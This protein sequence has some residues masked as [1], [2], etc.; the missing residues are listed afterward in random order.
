MNK[1]S[2]KHRKLAYV[3]A[4]IILLIPVIWLG[5]PSTGEEGSGGELAQLR[6]QYE[7][8]ESTL[9]DVDPSSASMNFVLLG[10]RGIATNLLWM[11][12]KD[13]Q[14]RKEWAKL[15]ST[16]DSIILLQPH[17][18]KVWDFQGW[19]LAYNVSAEWDAVED[20]Y[21]W[22]KEGIKFLNEGVARNERFPELDWKIGNLH[23]QKVGRSDEWKQFRRFYKVDPNTERYDG[24]PD[25]E[26]N[27][28][29]LDNYQVAK[30]KYLI[31]NEKE[32]KHKQHLQ[33]RM[34]FRAAPWHAQFD[35][36]NAMQR[37]GKFG[38][39]RTDAWAQGFKEWTTIFGREEFITPKGAVVLEWTD[40]DIE[41]LAKRDNVSVADKKH[42]TDRYQS[43][44]NYRFWR[45]RALSES[46][47]QTIDAHKAIYDGEVSFTEG[48]FDKA[49]AELEKGMSLY[50]SVLNKYPSLMAEDLAIEEGLKAVLLWRDIHDLKGIP[51]PESF[52]LKPLW[53]KEQGRVP[54]LQEDLR[55]D[56]GI[57]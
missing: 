32:L 53:I 22:V 40:D 45:T 55:R 46:E 24:G 12:A 18:M 5:M 8:G 17:Y 57:Q 35:Y 29:R 31:A 9:G 15:R 14:E 3:I 27:P 25:P 47:Q 20:R 30:Q 50:A 43:T 51:A 38:K 42:W 39:E 54:G 16:V 23:G 44:A 37:E 28:E 34:L 56:L 33:M 7:L 19:N 21:F 26:I 13:Y 1:L 6:V 49:Q 11:D 52:P 36:A 41:N 2:S 10:L 48:K 4:I